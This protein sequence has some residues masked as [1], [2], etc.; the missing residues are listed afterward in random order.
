[1][2]KT[3]KEENTYPSTSASPYGIEL[4][5]AGKPVKIA[6]EEKTGLLITE[7]GKKLL[8]VTSKEAT[9]TQKITIAEHAVAVRFKAPSGGLRL[10]PNEGIAV[11]VDGVPVQGSLADPTEQMKIYAFALYTLGGTVLFTLLYPLLTGDAVPSAD[12]MMAGITGVGLIALGIY[13]SKIP[14][15]S[16]GIG[17][18]LGC[19]MSASYSFSMIAAASESG[20]VQISWIMIVGLGGSTIFLLQGLALAL[21]MRRNPALLVPT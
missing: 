14:R 19:L 15:L 16:M 11:S 3:L 5:I 12:M 9:K 18:A 10:I 1:M 21:R 7:S 4:E 2:N 6:Y 20:D 13:S 8:E 17:A